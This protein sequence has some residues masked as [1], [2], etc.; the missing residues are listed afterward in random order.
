FRFREALGYVMD[1][2]RLGNKYLA[3]TEPWK[4]IKEDKDRT[5][6]ILNLALNLTAN[7]AI[8]SA[9]FLPF[10]VKKLVEMLQTD[11][12][13]WRKAGG[14]DLLKSGRRLGE[15][16]LLFEK[17]EDEVIAF[18]VNKL[19]KTNTENEKVPATILPV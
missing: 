13:D 12:L 7:L 6:T 11:T 4:T 15:P 14:I 3:D 5:A 16:V 19:M 1:L 2:A 18:Q 9:P 10:T 17:I 8:V